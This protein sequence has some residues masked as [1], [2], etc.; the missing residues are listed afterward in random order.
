[1]TKCATVSVGCRETVGGIVLAR[2]LVL[3]CVCVHIT[4]MDEPICVCCVDAYVV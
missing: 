4:V 2:C 3:L 1:M